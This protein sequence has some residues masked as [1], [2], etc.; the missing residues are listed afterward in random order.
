MQTVVIADD[1]GPT[2]AFLR[3]ILRD[4]GYEVVGEARNGREAIE[5][6]ERLRPVFA[7]LDIS[8]PVMSGDEAARQILLAKSARHVII[9]SSVTMGGMFEAMRAL[10]CRV[11]AKPFHSPEKLLREL[12]EAEH[13]GETSTD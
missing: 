10:G 4:G 9:A 12:R 1:L 11:I 5:L 13:D 3:R 2:R 6:C 7:I 8:M